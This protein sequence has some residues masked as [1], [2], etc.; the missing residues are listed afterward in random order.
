MSVLPFLFRFNI[1]NHPDGDGPI[2]RATFIDER[3]QL[4]R[5]KQREAVWFP[6]SNIFFRKVLEGISDPS[7]VVTDLRPGW[8]R[9]SPHDHAV[10]DVTFIQ[11][12]ARVQHS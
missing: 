8:E 7:A 11:S 5:Y 1:A 2:D 12:A 6:G 9:R 4:R 3:L 10:N